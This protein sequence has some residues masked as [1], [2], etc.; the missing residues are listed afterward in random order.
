MLAVAKVEVSAVVDLILNHTVKVIYSSGTA[1]EP[2]Q[3]LEPI[4]PNTTVGYKV[5][6]HEASA[7]NLMSMMIGK[8]MH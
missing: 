3:R 4:T 6:G 5:G 8:L 1:D 2:Y 7:E